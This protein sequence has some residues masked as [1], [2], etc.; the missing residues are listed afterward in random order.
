MR[1]F[2]REVG[3]RNISPFPSPS[4][5]SHD[6]SPPLRF[7]RQRGGG[8]SAGRCGAGRLQPQHRNRA[9][10]VPRRPRTNKSARPDYAWTLEMFRRIRRRNPAIALEDRPDAR[11]GRNQR[12]TA[13]HAGRSV[14]GGLPAADVGPISSAVAAADAGGAICPAGGV[15][16]SRRAGPANR[17][18]ARGRRAVRP[19]ELPCPRNGEANDEL[20]K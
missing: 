5:P 4:S 1:G 6:R 19:F 14:R 12:R 7:R 9:A 10:A 13:R 20:M 11:P 2:P 8:R 16:A 15:R 17:L 18:R 3:T